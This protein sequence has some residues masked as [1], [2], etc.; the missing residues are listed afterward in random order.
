MN[1]KIKRIWHFLWYEDSWASFA[2]DA[3][4][5]II[6]GKFVIYPLLGSMLGTSLP[7]VA[8]VSSSMEHNGMD[9][10]SW[11]Y[12]NNEYYD[13]I[14]I[15]KSNFKEYPLS[16]G[17]NK[18]DVIILTGTSF[19]EIKEGEVIVFLSKGRTEPIIH[20]VISVSEDHIS[21]K[22]DNNPNQLSFEKYIYDDEIIGKAVFKIPL[23]GWVKVIFLEITGQI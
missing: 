22:G 2:A 7:V 23:L 5:I 12:E 3:I 19:S 13:N 1:S 6:L 10:D 21:T 11:W 8:V 9:F 4:I 15:E 16:D 18:G 17:F 20:R 14:K